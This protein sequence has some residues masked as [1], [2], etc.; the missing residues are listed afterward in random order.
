MLPLRKLLRKYSSSFNFD[1]DIVQKQ[2]GDTK[3]KVSVRS[4]NFSPA[5]TENNLTAAPPS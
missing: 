2:K 3:L 4:V 5:K 1:L